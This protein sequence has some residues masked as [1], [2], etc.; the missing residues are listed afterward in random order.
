[1]RKTKKI[2][3]AFLILLVIIVATF[4][5]Y[6]NNVDLVNPIT[7]G[8]YN[9]LKFSLKEKGYAPN[10]LVVSGKRLRWHNKLQVLI[11]GAAKKSK[12]LKGEA[13]DFIVFD[14][15]EDGVSDREDVDIVYTILDKQI[16]KSNGGIGTYKTKKFWLYRQMIHIDCRG[17]RARWEESPN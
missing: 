11:S 13:M 15:N 8:Y 4:F 2:L 6:F 5:F 17:S 1:M 10:L 16:I 14:V 7:Q 3:L 12:H 9:E